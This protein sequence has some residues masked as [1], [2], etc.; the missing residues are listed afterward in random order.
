MEFLLI[1]ISLMLTALFMI[2]F[3]YLGEGDLGG[4]MRHIRRQFRDE[5][6]GAGLIISYL[7]VS[8]FIFAVLCA[9]NNSYW[10]VDYATTNNALWKKYDRV[11]EVIK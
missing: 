11:E 2:G 10:H 6:L 3:I 4:T 8:F 1:L 9:L 5:I 7:A